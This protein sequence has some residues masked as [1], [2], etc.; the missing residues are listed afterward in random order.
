[1]SSS[2]KAS[3]SYNKGAEMDKDTEHAEKAIARI[4][5]MKEG[6]SELVA[7]LDI[8]DDTFGEMDR[9]ETYKSINHTL[10]RWQEKYEDFLNEQGQSFT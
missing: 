7:L 5:K 4:D 8:A 10:G 3:Y 2:V 1:M 9:L 6:L